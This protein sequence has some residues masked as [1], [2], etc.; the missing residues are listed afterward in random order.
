VTLA[1]IANSAAS[2]L[3]LTGSTA[4]TTSQPVLNMTQTW[5]N[6]ATVFTG[7]KLNVTATA[8]DATSLLLDLQKGGTSQFNIRQDGFVSALN[9]ITVGDSVGIATTSGGS[10]YKL[11]WIGGTGMAFFVGGVSSAAFANG[12]TVGSAL[13]FGWSST[14]AA[15]ATQDTALFRTAAGVVEVNNGTAGTFREIKAR[16]AVFGG[17][18]PT[19]SGTCA[20]TTQT[21][22]NTAGTFT[23]SGAC[24]AGTYILTFG[25]TAP[26]GWSCVASDQTTAADYTKVNQTASSTT[27]ATFTATTANS[28]VIN[29][30]CVAY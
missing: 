28:D 23:A 16:S 24:A 22:G 5:N 11:A 8:F 20:V 17:T 13:G 19:A 12:V 21:G 2:T 10:S 9:G 3:T 14:A 1:G 27:T 29:Y 7:I 25:F 26:T 30:H 6:G 4:L 18:A 15:G